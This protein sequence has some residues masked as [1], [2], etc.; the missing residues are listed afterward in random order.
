M[1][2]LGHPHPLPNTK[3]RPSTRIIYENN[4]FGSTLFFNKKPLFSIQ[5]QIYNRKIG[6]RALNVFILMPQ[7]PSK[8]LI[9][10]VKDYF[11]YKYIKTRSSG[12]YHALLSSSCGG[13]SGW[14]AEG[15]KESQKGKPL[16]NFC[17]TLY[18]SCNLS[19][20][21]FTNIMTE[22]EHTHT[23]TWNNA[24]II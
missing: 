11:L 15:R 7:L 2:N 19:P 4:L 3:I 22:E 13:L 23:H 14:A 17:I 8:F 18:I 20:K 12:C 1:I 6:F 16:Y 9:Y 5:A 10:L 24:S 21:I